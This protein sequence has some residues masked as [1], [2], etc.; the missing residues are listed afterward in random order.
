MKI[1]KF[2][3]SEYKNLVDQT[4]EFDK[5]L[6]ALLVGQ[7]GLG[8]S[9]L[10][11]IISSIF[12]ELDLA[13]K[14]EDLNNTKSSIFYDFDLIY[15]CKGST[16]RLQRVNNEF[17]FEILLS[18]KFKE[19]LR[20]S[21]S[22]F[23][24][25]RHNLLPDYIIGYYSGENKRIRK[26]FERHHEI[27]VNELKK[28]KTQEPNILG[29][30]FFTDQNLGELLFFSL[31]VFRNNDL[32][33][34]RIKKLLEKYIGIEPQSTVN[35][36]FSNPDF[37]KNYPEKNAN[38][39]PDN[40]SKDVEDPFWGIRGSLDIFLRKL[41]NNNLNKSIPISFIDEDLNGREKDEFVI[42]NDLNYDT[43]I[44]DLGSEFN[45]PIKLF[46]ILQAADSIGIVHEIDATLN[47]NGAKIKHRFSE[48]S[49]GEQQML[50]VMGLVLIA[51]EYDTLFLFDEPDTHLNPMWQRDFVKLLDEFNLKN[52]NS[53]IIV[54]THSPLIVQSSETADVFLFR[55]N[56]GGVEVDNN[57]HHI[58][59]WRIDQVLVSEYFNLPTARPA[60]LDSYM[61][62]RERILSK[63]K[64][65]DSD[66]QNLKS[67][68]N[69][70][71]ALP[72]GET[73]N[74]IKAMI[75]IR[76]ITG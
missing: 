38:D 4:F 76:K 37:Y 51:G 58:H 63:R 32:Y 8:K 73:I 15:A 17:N 61:E 26:L 56:G 54:A 29:K 35:I 34:T 10:L 60:P 18:N 47:K 3:I 44:E 13:E 66:I 25:N 64:L 68:E 28:G 49:E 23:K 65:S 45:T 67:F 75:L 48:L 46:D 40:L 53:H 33:G 69:E 6:I 22:A 9:N 20:L 59:N 55:S 36:S 70:F 27:R 11:E 57:D 52:R 74:D 14:I 42:F 2:W 5:G 24:K 72:T 43:L 16:I 19:G 12:K 7:N 1:K 30:L 21:F 71:G 39:L 31:W 50:T 62:L 41:Y